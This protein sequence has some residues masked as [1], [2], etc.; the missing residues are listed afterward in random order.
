MSAS[1]SCKTL[2]TRLGSRRPSSPIALCMLYEARVIV[3][4][5]FTWTPT[6]A[7]FLRFLDVE[8]CDA[9]R[10]VLD[11]LPARLDDVAHQAREYLVGD[12]RLR[13][14]DPK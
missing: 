12:V 3:G 9:Q 8:I 7:G 6:S 13:D 11:K 2:R 1:I 5:L 4:R 14:L 10:I